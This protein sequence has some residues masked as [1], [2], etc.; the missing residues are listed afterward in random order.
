MHLFL[1]SAFDRCDMSVSYLGQLTSGGRGL[2]PIEQEAEYANIPVMT[3]SSY[4]P[5]NRKP[6]LRFGSSQPSQYSI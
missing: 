2:V 1:V 3:K 5:S 6:F 4:S